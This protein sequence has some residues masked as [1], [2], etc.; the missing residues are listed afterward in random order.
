MKKPGFLSVIVAA[1][2][3]ASAL[4]FYSPE[5]ASGLTG[6]GGIDTHMHLFSISGKRQD[7]NPN[8]GGS[9]SFRSPH[10][11]TSSFTRT[12]QPPSLLRPSN[13]PEEEGYT[14]AVG[15]LLKLM[16]KRNVAKAMVMPPPQY[17]G[18]PGAYDY[19]A[20]LPAIQA[21]GGR[22]LLVAG[23]GSLNPLIMGTNADKVAPQDIE[24][25]KKKAELIIKSGAVAFGEMTALHVCMSERHH[26]MAAP[27]DHPLFLLLADIAA[28]NGMP[29]DL[30]MEAVTEK[31]ATPQKLLEACSK[32]P[33]TLP[34]TIPGLE[35][36]LQHNRNAI[37]VWQHIGWD[38]T[39]HMTTE[40]LNRLLH[41]HPNLFLSI[42]V[43]GWQQTRLEGRFRNTIT[44]PQGRIRPEWKQLLSDH[45][46]RFM[47]GGDAF[48][49]ETG[50]KNKSSESF[51]ESWRAINNLL[52]PARSK[53]SWKTA[54]Q[55]Y[56]VHK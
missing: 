24:T 51:K 41:E 34:P 43:L 44:N 6:F 23:G 3:F 5:Y 10:T 18:Q 46:G 35:R 49:G 54:E 38:N 30:H 14:N 55:V 52:E 17:R 11:K 2:T 28:S 27:P 56:K 39:G 31:M 26:Y 33:H 37:F 20:L 8:R 29:I 53:V 42:R 50:F 25:F 12:K 4:Y 21:G 45:P 7:H 15:P 36:L 32:N 47:V 48:V 22:L 19:K 16:D 1:M 13:A 40:L 9:G